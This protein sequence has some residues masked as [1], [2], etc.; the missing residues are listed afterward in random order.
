MFES[1]VSKII[2]TF[3]NTVRAVRSGAAEVPVARTRRDRG[4]VPRLVK[5]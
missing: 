5:P 2:D 1:I 3:R 4:A